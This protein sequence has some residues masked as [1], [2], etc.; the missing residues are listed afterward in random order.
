MKRSR[1]SGSILIDICTSFAM[2]LCGNRGLSQ[3]FQVFCNSIQCIE[4]KHNYF[5]CKKTTTL[6]FFPPVFILFLARLH[7][8]RAE[9]RQLLRF[10]GSMAGGE[11]WR[12]TDVHMAPRQPAELSNEEEIQTMQ[13]KLIA[14]AVAGLIA[15]P[16]LAQSNVTISGRFA[17]G[18][19]SYKLSGGGNTGHDTESRVSDQSSRIIFNVVEDLGGGLKAWGQLDARFAQGTSA[20]TPPASGAGGAKAAGA[21][22]N[23][24]ASG[25]H[26]HGPDA[27]QVG[28]VHPSAAGTCITTNWPS[29]KP[30]APAPCSPSSASA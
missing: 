10:T 24:W 4:N 7:G 20:A 16:A 30:P 3:V 19:E 22:G 1:S 21:A 26:R 12:S 18:W 25:Q 2:L 11:W 9:W 29:W 23:T 27:C 5:C 6:L 17:A 28:Q 8:G 14:A 15:V 13:K